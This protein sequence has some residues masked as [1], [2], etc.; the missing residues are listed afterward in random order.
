MEVED[1]MEKRWL[2]QR[3]L[4]VSWKSIV[5]LFGY[6]CSS[7]TSLQRNNLRLWVKWPRE[8]SSTR[9]LANSW[10]PKLAGRESFLCTASRIGV[11][12]PQSVKLSDYEMEV[13]CLKPCGMAIMVNWGNAP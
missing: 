4:A 12:F 3:A 10:S 9:S 1:F 5:L 7:V 11:C 8:P 6:R 13:T 2:M